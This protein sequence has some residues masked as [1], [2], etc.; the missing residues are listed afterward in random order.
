MNTKAQSSRLSGNLRVAGAV[1]MLALLSLPMSS[2]TGASFPQ[3][4]L[5][6]GGNAV[7]PNILLIL[8]DSGSMAGGWMPANKDLPTDKS[9]LYDNVVDRSYVS[10]T[11]YY[12]PS[13]TYRPWRTASLDLTDRLGMADFKRVSDSDTNLSGAYDLRNK[14][15]SYFYVPT[16]SNPGGDAGNYDKYRI[17]SSSSS[18][19]YNNGVVQK[20]RGTVAL[21]GS[22]SSIN[23]ASWSS[24]IQM[25]VKSPDSV[26]ITI[27]GGGSRSNIYIYSTS[28]CS[29][30]KR[31]NGL[32]VS[33]TGSS[34]PR[35]VVID[36]PGS[37]IYLRVYNDNNRNRVSNINW[38]AVG[39]NWVDMTPSG[40]TSAL[41]KAEIENF[42]NWYQYHRTRNKMAKAGASEAFGRLGRN[43][44]VGFDSIWN[45]GGVSA[46]T[47][48]A[49]PAYPI[50]VNTGNGLFQD[51]GGGTNRSD[52]YARL[53]AA[54]ASGNTPLKGALQRAGRY[55]SVR[56]SDRT[57]GSQSPW[58]TG[59][60]D[61][62]LACRQNYAILTTDGY[63]NSNSGF[64]S[65]A[66]RKYSDNTTA[67][68]GSGNVDMGT[69]YPFQDSN[70]GDGYSQTLADVA[71]YYWKNDL[72]PDMDAPVRSSTDDPADWQHMVTFGVS[73]G[74]QGT[75]N[76]NNPKPAVWPDPT[77]RE[78]ATRIDDLWHASVNGHGQFV[79]A[80][81]TE[82][83]ASA[84]TRA[85]EAI[86]SRTASGSNIASS[87][88]KTD[89][90]TLTFV[91]G[92]TSGSWVGDMAASP[93]N[94]ALSGVSD[95]PNWR[96]SDTFG[97][98]GANKNFA[99][100]TILTSKG[101][102]AALFSYGARGGMV[103]QSDFAARTG[104][105]DA[106]SAEDNI[107]Y[108]RG[109]QS[110]E[111]GQA[112]GYLRKRAWPI[113]DIVDSSP[114]YADDTGTVYIGSND[115]M[116]HGIDAANGQVLFSYVPKGVDFA[117]MA[118]LSST[119]YEHRY[120]VD[121]QID[122]ITKNNQ[123]N[124]KDIL[125]GALG[126][127]GRGVF[128]LDVSTP[129]RMGVD[130]VLW[131][132]TTQSAS[133]DTD[134]GYVLAPVRIRSGNG[135]KTYA[136]VANGIDSAN[137]SAVLYAYELDANGGIVGGG[138]HKLVAD[139]GGNG[140]RNG[141]MSMGLADLNGDGKV[142]VVYGGDLKGNV[143]RWDFSG[144]SLPNAPIKL[145]HAEDSA[146]N[147]QTIT[148]GIA[149]SRSSSGQ[150]FIGFGTGSFISQSDI[151]GNVGYTAQTQSVYGLIDSGVAIPSR[152]SLQDRSIVSTG[153]DANGRKTREFESPSDLPADKQGWYMDLPVPERVISAPT[154]LTNGD[155]WWSSINPAVGSD[156]SSSM[157]T[158]YVNHIDVFTGTSGGSTGISTGMP[159]EVNVTNKLATVGTGDGL[160][161]Q[162]EDLP[163][164]PSGAPSRVSWR[165]IVPQQ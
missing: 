95:T 58:R 94:A 139:A 52:F 22:I 47:S 12:N 62:E 130:N 54:G 111:I 87:S 84:L 31:G 123:K 128:A 156:C 152:D 160:N 76:P 44:R 93:F 155:M 21:S 161:T 112:D 27:S 159:T 71:Y 100:R 49:M 67:G 137:G 41:Q 158:G 157:G 40:N 70:R 30:D 63:W 121:G 117:A 106:V 144:A 65:T 55:F 102:T 78:D 8:D 26:T 127:G 109:D 28:D 118:N 146:G 132:R 75:L 56:A 57:N 6:T 9:R 18:T 34:D 129:D 88:T 141:L 142:D 113:G 91:A 135:G 16:T 83:F 125:V 2:A 86:D 10:N 32:L 101:G 153:V 92:F 85:L 116:L 14:V 38:S 133:D 45:E 136:L 39:G 82:K 148:G 134:M 97:S 143:W 50:P 66:I 42:A 119:T 68:D 15:E 11:I 59:D 73:I 1:A 46:D 108:L 24:C 72:R 23:A 19:S 162:S 126:R 4:P 17:A 7:P 147:S 37:A 145:F 107:A 163:K 60:G 81:N 25:S 20:M 165:E 104:Q 120:F 96:L 124:G 90:A 115:G 53:H 43:Y 61:D 48:G 35:E 151:P 33:D 131:D 29:V 77:R 105:S 154:I 3:N 110:K 13:M 64:D 150:I 5:L 164:P 51:A 122:V 149:V 103:G 79:V 99:S 98:K 36:N 114:A 74:Q 138:P 69:G 80:S 140:S 89:T